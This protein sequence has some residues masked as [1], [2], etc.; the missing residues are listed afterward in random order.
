MILTIHSGLLYA[1][2][3]SN[4]HEASLVKHD[5]SR[6]ILPRA[7]HA[8]LLTPLSALEQV[9]CLKLLLYTSQILIEGGYFNERT[10]LL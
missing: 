4:F 5:E 3:L 10:P 7:L 9:A 6:Q 1:P 2:K 8:H